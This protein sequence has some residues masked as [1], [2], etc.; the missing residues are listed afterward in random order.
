MMRQMSFGQSL[1]SLLH[2]MKYTADLKTQ[3]EIPFP[4]QLPDADVAYAEKPDHEQT[5]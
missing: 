1:L 3:S 5:N 2:R 4:L